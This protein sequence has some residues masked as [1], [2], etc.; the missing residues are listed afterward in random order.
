MIWILDL[1]HSITPIT[2]WVLIIMMVI[3]IYSMRKYRLQSEKELEGWRDLSLHR[4]TRFAE[5]FDD[6]YRRLEALEKRK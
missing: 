6:L 3:W 1:L 2:Q 4:G 5:T